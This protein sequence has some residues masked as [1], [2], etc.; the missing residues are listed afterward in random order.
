M[1]LKG[2]GHYTQHIQKL[3]MASYS[4]KKKKIPFI[5][6]RKWDEALEK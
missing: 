6:V 4:L 2:V 5:L 3:P 1:S